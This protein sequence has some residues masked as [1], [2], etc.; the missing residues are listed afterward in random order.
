MTLRGFREA[1]D[2][3]AFQRVSGHISEG[4]VVQVHQSSAFIR[5][6]S[7]Q[8]AFLH[9]DDVTSADIKSLDR[10]LK[11][12]VFM[13]LLKPGHVSYRFTWHYPEL[14]LGSHP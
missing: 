10:V 3:E 2:A 14:S 4:E 9:Q 7:G 6:E 1:W 5:L 12:S 11:V 13:A 8:T